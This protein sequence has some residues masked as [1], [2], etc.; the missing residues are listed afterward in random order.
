MLTYIILLMITAEDIKQL[1]AIL[2][3]TQKDLA[4]KIGT[5]IKTIANYEAGTVIPSGKQSLL[6]GLLI[7]ARSNVSNNTGAVNTG[8]VGG[9]NV[10]VIGDGYE[11]IIDKEKI[12]LI[13]GDVSKVYLQK[14]AS[15]EAEIVR[16]EAIIKSKDETI[17]AKDETI[18]ILRKK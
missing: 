18:E 1:R 15:L 16:L 7:E 5:S 12:E 9:H 3:L 10:S 14:I 4:L 17:A 11:K 13:R 6:K 2:G 8:S